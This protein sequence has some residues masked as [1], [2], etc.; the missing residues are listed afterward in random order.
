[1]AIRR[2]SL[3]FDGTRARRERERQGLT[4]ADLTERCERAGL[5]IDRT[6][7]SRWETG[8]F[9]PTAPRLKIL[10]MALDVEVAELLTPTEEIKAECAS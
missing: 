9:G 2:L 7:L 3:P 4:L 8:V 1:M 6:T 10:A 5:R